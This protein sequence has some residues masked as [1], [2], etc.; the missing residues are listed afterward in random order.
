MGIGT[1]GKIFSLPI[2]VNKD[3]CSISTGFTNAELSCHPSLYAVNS[4]PA[5]HDVHP[6]LRYWLS[7]GLEQLV[8]ELR[9]VVLDTNLLKSFFFHCNVF[10]RAASKLCFQNTVTLPGMADN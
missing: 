1:H 10:S 6:A 5:G 9:I 7:L 8:N 3:G 2:T 4:L